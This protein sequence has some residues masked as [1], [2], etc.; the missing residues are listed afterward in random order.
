MLRTWSINESLMGNP[1]QRNPDT[2]HS[3]NAAFPI[4]LK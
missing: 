2:F 1:R 3:G 4:L